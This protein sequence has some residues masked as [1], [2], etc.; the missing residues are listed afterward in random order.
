V[1][2]VPAKQYGEKADS[3][4]SLNR[5]SRYSLWRGAARA[6]F[7]AGGASTTHSMVPIL[8]TCLPATINRLPRPISPVAD[9]LLTVQN[10]LSLSQ[11]R[12][13]HTT[14]KAA[15][16]RHIDIYRYPPTRYH[17]AAIAVSNQYR[18]PVIAPNEH[19]R[20][21]TFDPAGPMKSAR[22]LQHNIRYATGFP[23]ALGLSL[24]SSAPC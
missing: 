9:F 20:V 5:L 17:R 3:K 21:F 14:I 15:F 11:I 13:P 12:S 19:L 8:P 6:S 18:S 24:A 22:Y 23:K 7:K 16:L 2:V 4:V 10:N 1:C